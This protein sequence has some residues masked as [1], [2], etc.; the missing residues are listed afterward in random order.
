MF[1]L[2]FL[3]RI[4]FNFISALLYFDPLKDI[5]KFEAKYKDLSDMLKEKEGKLN[6]IKMRANLVLTRVTFPNENV[7]NK[8]N[9]MKG[10]PCHYHYGHYYYNHYGHYYYYH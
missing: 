3:I 6:E 7:Q 9:S 10:L 4:L 8:T 5:T 1:Q 2:Y